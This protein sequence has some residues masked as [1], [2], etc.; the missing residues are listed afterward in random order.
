MKTHTGKARIRAR[1]ASAP[2]YLI[3]GDEPLTAGEAADALR[4]AARP[5]GFTEREVFFVERANTGPWDEIYA[6]AQSLSLF[7]SRRMLEVRLPGGKPGTGAKVLQ[8]LAALAGP[9]LLV[10]VITGEL[11]WEAQKA[12]WVQA[13]DRAGVLGAGRCAWRRRSCR[14]GSARARRVR[15]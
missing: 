4:A 3:A 5:Q 10:L 6:A 12:A 11:D 15:A 13:I 1:G 7:A 8:E 14:P 2:V 9:D